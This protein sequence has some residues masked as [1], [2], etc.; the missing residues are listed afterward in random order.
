MQANKKAVKNIARISLCLAA[1]GASSLGA[2]YTF[3]GTA[4]AFGK[5]GFDGGK[6]SESANGGN[7]R[8]PNN[9]YGALFGTLELDI[10]G[11]G[12]MSAGLG[13]ALNTL[14]YDSSTR[15]GGEATGGDYIGYYPGF[16]GHKEA[17]N[18]GY[19]LH[20]TYVAYDGEYLGIKAGRYESE[21]KDWFSDWNQGAEGYIKLG[22]AKLWGFYSGARAMVSSSWFWDYTRFAVAGH[23]LFA[24]GLDVNGLGELAPG[25]ELSVYYYGVPELYNAPGVKIGYDSNPSFEGSGFRS[26]TR[27]IALFPKNASN[28][29]P[30][31]GEADYTEYIA[32][33]LPLR[34][35]DAQNTQSLL[36]K[37]RFDVDNHYFGAMAYKNFGNA[38]A[39]IGTYGDPFGSVDIWTG[40]TYDRGA[41]LS[42][43]VGRDA[44]SGIGFVGG[45]YGGFEWELL[46][47]ITRSPRSDE[48]S[49]AL[50]LTQ[51]IREDLSV[52]LKLEY[53][54]DV[55]KAGYSVGYD[56]PV[57]T[58]SQRN[59]RSH[60]MAWL[61]HQF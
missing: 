27:V 9:S 7:G 6:V 24:A 22:D 46:G 45:V 21:G 51:S 31:K 13:G 29:K 30:F 53:F 54:N 10:K 17:T 14:V 5:F 61:S 4:E 26:Q 1:L 28:P 42:D 40:S 49:L 33:G 52:K 3:G 59:D 47:R 48:E 2:D 32:F 11:A 44:M 18:H 8:Y 60:A 55:T 50:M 39:W 12:G 15:Q 43:M 35:G 37:Q 20:N 58:Q 38:N 57:L 34:E 41:A 56:T 36:L 23:K 16:Y 19:I 25:F